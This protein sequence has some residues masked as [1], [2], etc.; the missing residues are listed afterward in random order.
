MLEDQLEH[1]IQTNNGELREEE[2]GLTERV[3]EKAINI[4]LKD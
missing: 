3:K 2:Q 4:L 1:F